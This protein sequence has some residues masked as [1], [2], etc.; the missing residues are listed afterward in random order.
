[1]FKK[2]VKPQ[3][4]EG[5]SF[6]VELHYDLKTNNFNLKAPGV[7]TVM[8]YG[9]LQMGLSVCIQKQAEN[10]V[11]ARLTA[12]ANASKIKVAGADEIPGGKA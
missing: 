1:M 9:L 8:L 5:D 7:P 10:Q 3:Q 11:M 4:S 6:V 2:E 12:A